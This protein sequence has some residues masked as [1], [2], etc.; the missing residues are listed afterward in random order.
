MW[1]LVNE[2]KVTDTETIFLKIADEWAG[3]TPD[4][5]G[6]KDAQNLCTAIRKNT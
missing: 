2:T 6:Q 5:D 4:L 3:S 1:I